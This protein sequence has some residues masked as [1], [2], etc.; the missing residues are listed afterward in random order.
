MLRDF[1]CLGHHLKLDLQKSISLCKNQGAMSEPKDRQFVDALARGFAVLEC[2]SRA[3][4]PLGNG[5]ISRLVGLPPSSVSRLT[6]TLTELGYIRRSSSER[7]YE[8][9]PKNLTLGYPILAGMSLL[10]RARPYLKSISEDTGETVAL[11]VRDSLHISFVEV[12]PGTNLLAVRLATGGRLRM[13]VSAAGVAIT[14]AL[15]ERKRWSILNRLGADM[16]R[17]GESFEAFERALKEC[18]KTGYAMIRNL[19]QEGVGGV[20]VPLLWQGSV[21]A[22]TIP[23]STGSFS[24]QRMRNELVPIL[25][26]AAQEIGMAPVGRAAGSSGDGAGSGDGA[27]G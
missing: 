20:S 6:Y 1:T 19:W 2:L 7:T 3:Q 16:E 21:A 13:G 26:K 25:L 9:T 17:R 27:R 11:A 4:H 8:L 15:S 22:L 5:E 18:D 10:D 24:K 23:I 14:A 12:M